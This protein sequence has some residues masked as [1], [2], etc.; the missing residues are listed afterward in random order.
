MTFAERLREDRRRG[1]LEMLE[2]SHPTGLR[3]PVLRDLL[4]DSGRRASVDAVRNDLVWLSEQGMAETAC[5]EDGE[6]A[7]AT[8]RGIDVA[9]GYA[10]AHGV[11]QRD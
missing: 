2:A 7:T 11:R 5:C 1:I 4:A 8:E 9:R 3:V 10:R 6:V